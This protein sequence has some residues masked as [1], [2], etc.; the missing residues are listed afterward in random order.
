VA[1]LLESHPLRARDPVK[2]RRDDI[3][4]CGVVPSVDDETGNVD[5]V[6]LVDDVPL[7]QLSCE[8]VDPFRLFSS[9]INS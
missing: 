3:V 8:A 5:P 6:Q 4:L 7:F 9:L 1:A 2:E